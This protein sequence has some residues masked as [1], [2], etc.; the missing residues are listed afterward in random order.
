MSGEIRLHEQLR[1]VW[2]SRVKDE[3]IVRGYLLHAG[4]SVAKPEDKQQMDG[5]VAAAAERW[6]VLI[7]HCFFYT[8]H[9]DS[10][11][12]SGALLTD[13]F[14]QVTPCTEDKTLEGIKWQ[15]CCLLQR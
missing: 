11:Q 6:F 4:H 10:P 3:A 12:F 1:T 14:G 2:K 7:G 9:R 15:V 13:V 8:I 5:D